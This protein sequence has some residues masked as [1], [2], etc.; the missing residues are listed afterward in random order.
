M[1][2]LQEKPRFYGDSR[3]IGDKYVKSEL[4]Q[5]QLIKLVAKALAIAGDFISLSH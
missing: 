5:S 4:D 1:L 2:R 3:V